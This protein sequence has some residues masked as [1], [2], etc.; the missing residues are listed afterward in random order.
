MYKG[1]LI[2]VIVF[3]T[4]AARAGDQP[5]PQAKPAAAEQPEYTRGNEKS[6]A[7]PHE[8]R[9]D[10]FLGQRNIPEAIKEFDEALKLDPKAQT[11]Y[12]KKGMA[13]YASGAPLDAVPLM[14]K[15]IEVNSRDKSWAWWPLYHK[16]VAFG[17]SGD[18]EG[19]I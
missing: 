12:V 9:G 3:F 5:P 19:A 10:E 14:D 6:P 13:L 17:I 15:A 11:V 2:A 16:G 18:M 4:F 7:Y 1:I 8:Q